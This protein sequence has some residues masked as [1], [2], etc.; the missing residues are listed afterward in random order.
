[1]FSFQDTDKFKLFEENY[2]NFRKID[3]LCTISI[4]FTFLFVF[5][6]WLL[7]FGMF[8]R[9]KGTLCIFCERKY[10][11]TTCFYRIYKVFHSFRK[12]NREKLLFSRIYNFYQFFRTFINFFFIF[13][14]KIDKTGLATLAH[15]TLRTY[16]CA[17]TFAHSLLRAQHFVHA[18]VSPTHK[19]S[20]YSQILYNEL[21]F[22][23]LNFRFTNFLLLWIY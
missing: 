1:M 2:G 21:K 4:C 13:L 14:E 5:C 12:E 8:W 7:F 19:T 22:V 6:H 16:I 10:T 17:R 3:F 18:Q 20:L 15:K 23:L 9:K 11:K